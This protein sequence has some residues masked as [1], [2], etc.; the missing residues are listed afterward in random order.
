[1]RTSIKRFTAT[2]GLIFFATV[3]A[4]LLAEAVVRIVFEEPIQPRFVI[5]S[6]YGVRTNQP[7]IVTRHYVPGDYEV[8]IKNNSVG[9]RGLHEYSIEKPPNVY[10]IAPS[11]SR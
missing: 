6:G 7:N 2:I 11:G 10:R 9:M 8:A 1:M 3:L 5:D 4:F